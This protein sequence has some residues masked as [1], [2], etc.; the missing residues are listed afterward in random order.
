[1]LCKMTTPTKSEVN[2]TYGEAAEPEACT[3]PVVF[4][5][6]LPIR[7]H[8]LRISFKH[9]F[10]FCTRSTGNKTITHANTPSRL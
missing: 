1:L 5:T 6:D 10:H 4:T 2:E 9:C 7:S 3:D 8:I